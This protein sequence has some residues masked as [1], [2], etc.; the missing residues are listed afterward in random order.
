MVNI[1]RVGLAAFAMLV[2]ATSPMASSQN[3]SEMGGKGSAIAVGDWGG[4]HVSM[5]ITADGADFEFDCATGHIPSP[6]VLDG[7]GKFKANGTYKRERPAPAQVDD[8][9]E[10]SAVT[11]SGS[12]KGN[13][14]Q[15]H[16]EIPGQETMNLE[17]TRGE[18]GRLTKCA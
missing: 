3:S 13:V 15:L 1:L 8:V 5:T 12:V 10:G 4:D 14:M 9:S 11:Y 17:L 6:L 16:I 2:I 7:K 18:E